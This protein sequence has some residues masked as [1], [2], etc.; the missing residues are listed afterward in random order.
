M[1]NTKKTEI[2][3]ILTNEGLVFQ[4]WFGFEICEQF[5]S[6]QDAQSLASC[7][8]QALEYMSAQP[9]KVEV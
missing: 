7:I 6:E 5:E 2:Y 1:T 8:D 3:K 4:V 9:A